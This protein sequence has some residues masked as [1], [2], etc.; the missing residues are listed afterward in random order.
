[1][2]AW[3][4]VSAASIFAGDA[5]GGGTAASIVWRSMTANIMYTSVIR[6]QFHHQHCAQQAWM[7]WAGG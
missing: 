2:G 1:M 5:V 7:A 4:V 6:M 3:K